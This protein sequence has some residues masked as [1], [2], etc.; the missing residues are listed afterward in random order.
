MSEPSVP[1]VSTAIKRFVPCPKPISRADRFLTV[2]A[3]SVWLTMIIVFVLT[4]TLFW[5]SASYPGRMD[6]NQSKNLQTIPKSMYNAWNIFIGVSVPEMPKSWKVRIFF[7]IYVCYCFA[8]GT[9]FQAFFV[10]YLVEPGYGEKIETFQELLDSNVSYGFIAAADLG[11]RT[12]EFSD[13]LQFPLHV[14][15]TA[16]NRKPA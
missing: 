5:F 1:Y 6:E 13:H 3:A 10:S 4:S 15:W 12:M 14:V 9:V 7:L 11:M 16:L 2:F 8:M